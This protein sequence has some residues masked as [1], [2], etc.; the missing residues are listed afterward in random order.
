[1]PTSDRTVQRT[2][3]L[4]KKK[5]L[6][7]NYAPLVVEAVV[8]QPYWRIAVQPWKL[9]GWCRVSFRKTLITKRW[10]LVEGDGV[11][12]RMATHDDGRNFI[13]LGPE[14]SWKVSFIGKFTRR[15]WLMNLKDL[16][17]DV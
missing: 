1:M 9:P 13:G 3:V 17:E 2:Q 14:M 7:S 8:L 12:R 15:R 6:S 10:Q 4:F 16:S 11:S 5:Q